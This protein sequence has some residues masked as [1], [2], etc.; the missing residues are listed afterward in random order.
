[1]R[2]YKLSIYKNIHKKAVLNANYFVKKTEAEEHKQ[3]F[4]KAGL[5]VSLEEV[6]LTALEISHALNNLDALTHQLRG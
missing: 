3:R 2:F 5:P 1:M 4:T 6:N